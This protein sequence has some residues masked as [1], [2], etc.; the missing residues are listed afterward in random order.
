[1]SETAAS[2]HKPPLLRPEARWPA[3]SPLSAE[4]VESARQHGVLSIQRFLASQQLPA[5]YER[6]FTGL[7]IPMAAWLIRA[8]N[9]LQRPLMLA[10]G[11][12]QGSGKSTLASAL[13]LVLERCFAV[14]PCVLS[15][16]DFYRSRRER[17]ALG[18]GLH[19]LLATRG[20]PGTH[21]VDL[22]AQTLDRLRT[23]DKQDLIRL[24]VFDKHRDDQAPA[25]RQRLIAGRPSIVILEGWCLG[26][27]P[28]STAELA[29]PQNELE[30]REDP[31]GRWRRYVND[32]LAGP[33]QDLLSAMDY[34]FHMAAPDWESVSRWRWN[35]EQRLIRQLKDDYQGGLQTPAAFERFMAHYQRLS[36]SLLDDKGND[37]DLRLELDEQQRLTRQVF[38]PVT[39][40]FSH[41]NNS[42]KGS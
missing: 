30:A 5:A 26:A 37:A 10:I 3:D 17:A 7:I 22:L 16:D 19:P 32:Q 29:I 31:D 40:T 8:Q 23:A 38:N 34:R 21:D 1:M 33:Y 2:T 11:G 41:S 13:G 14:S 36:Q 20:V 15:L 12:A 18:R 4:S 6:V 27:R 42:N 9:T 39:M 35:Q 24:P 25:Q 28:Q